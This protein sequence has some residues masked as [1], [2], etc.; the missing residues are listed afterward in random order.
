MKNP[1]RFFRS[2]TEHQDTQPQP[3]TLP[4]PEE[5]AE[6]PAV[7]AEK[8][9]ETAKPA[10]D[11]IEWCR[12]QVRGGIERRERNDIFEAYSVF[13]TNSAGQLI[14]RY[15]H[16]YPEH[17]REFDLSYTRVLSFDEFNRRLLTELDRGDLKLSVYNACIKKAEDLTQNGTDRPEYEDLSDA[18][19]TAITSFCSA[20][21][22][23]IDQEY[24]HSDG[25][26]YCSCR[27]AVGG[28]IL[29]L[30][31]RK[32]LPHDALDSEAA[33]VSE[34]SVEAYDIDN[35]WI[36]GVCNRVREH[37]ASCSITKLTSEWSLRKETVYLISAEGFPDVGG[38]LLI[39]VADEAAFPHFGFYALDFSKK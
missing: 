34:V 22:T 12:T 31:F 11:F 21:D 32:P 15:Y 7:P 4:I 14:C 36:M 10:D 33:G 27:S 35:L 6:S 39:A 18:E 16:R 30:R 1:F 38:T 17:E 29:N 23:L 3:T 19:I 13:G 2:K 26:F 28:E 25:I 8:P 9:L 37:C 5:P 20:V 24:R